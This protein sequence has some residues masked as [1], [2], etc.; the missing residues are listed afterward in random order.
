MLGAPKSEG[1][2]GVTDFDYHVKP[3]IALM[4]VLRVTGYSD[5]LDGH[6]DEEDLSDVE[7]QIECL[8]AD[9]RTDTGA[10]L[11]R[12]RGSHGWR[13]YEWS[14][15]AVHRYEWEHAEKDLRCGRCE[16]PDNELYMVKNKLWAS[17]GLDGF[18]CFRCLEGA[19]GRRLVPAD[20]KPETATNTDEVHH[21]PE[22]RRRMGLA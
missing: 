10:S 20:F 14:N 7:F 13:V 19:I 4:W 5:E 22:L 15:G 16:S 3:G 8:V 1:V 21:S 9:Y 12:V 2:V 18:V 11:T 6:V 17:S